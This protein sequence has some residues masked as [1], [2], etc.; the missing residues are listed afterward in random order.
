MILSKNTRALHAAEDVANGI[1]N[2]LKLALVANLPINTIAKKHGLIFFPSEEYASRFEL[3][4]KLADYYN[5]SER[6]HFARCLLCP[7]YLLEPII[8]RGV[9]TGEKWIF[10]LC[11]KRRSHTLEELSRIFAV[12]VSVI[13]RQCEMLL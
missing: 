7:L 1:R 5:L 3:G 11:N 13:R 2:N 4:L 9:A 8:N 6:E 10:G 12:P